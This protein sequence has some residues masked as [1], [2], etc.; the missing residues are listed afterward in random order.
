VHL[1]GFVIRNYNE[2][3]AVEVCST[4]VFA[5]KVTKTWWGNKCKI[6]G[7]IL[8]IKIVWNKIRILKYCKST[9]LLK[10]TD[11]TRLWNIAFQKD[12]SMSPGRRFIKWLCCRMVYSRRHWEQKGRKIKC[13]DYET[14]SDC[15]LVKHKKL[16]LVFIS[17][18]FVGK[19]IQNQWI[20][21][22]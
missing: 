18:L 1:V 5:G 17:I 10:E 8:Q 14:R 21:F 22:L 20:L 2:S 3:R 12:A 19:I 4:F 9:C 13:K 7:L 6:C 16:L 15:V 11:N